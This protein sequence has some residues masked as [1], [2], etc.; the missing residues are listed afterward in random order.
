[1][2]NFV[3]EAG[4]NV[5]G[6]DGGAGC[7]SIR[8]EAHAQGR[9]RRRRRRHG[10]RRL[11]GRR[12][13][14]GVA[15]GLP[16]PPA[17]H[18][19]PAAPTA[20]GKKQ[21][22]PRR[23]RPRSC[24]CPRAPSSTTTTA[25]V[26]ADL[27]HAGDRWLAAA[28]GRGGKG[29]ARFLSNSRRAPTFAEQGEVGE[30][31]WLRLEL[32]LMAD[33]ALVGFPNVGKSHADLRGLGRQ[34]QDRRLPVHDA[35][36]QP[37]RGAP[38]RRR[39]D[40]GRRHPRPHRGRQRGQG[41]RPPVPPPRR[42]GPGAGCCCSTSPAA[43][44]LRPSEQER[45]LLDELE[46]YRPELLERPR[47]VVGVPRRHGRPGRSS[48]V[49]GSTIVS[50]VTGAG[51]AE[52]GRAPWPSRSRRARRRAPSPSAFVDPPA[53]ARGL[54][55]RA[56]RRAAASW[57]TAGR[58]PSAPSPCP[59]SPTSRRSTTCRSRLQAARRRQ[60]AGRG[61]RP[62]RRPRPHRQAQLRVRGQRLINVI[63]ADRR[64]QDRHVVD[65]RRPTGDID[66]DA[67]AKLC[68]EV[69]A[70]RAAGHRVV[71]VT[72]G[73]IAAGLPALGLGGDRRPTRRRH[74]PG[75][76]RRRPEPADARLRRAAS[77]ATAWWPARCCS[78]RS[79]S[80]DAPAVPA[81]PGHARPP[82]RA[83]RRAGRQRERRHRR[84]R[85]PLRRQR[86]HRRARGPPGRRRPAGAA[87]RRRR[88]A[89]RR[90]P[91]R[92]I[93]VAHRGD[94][95]RSTTSSKP[96]AGGAGLARGSGGMA[97][98]LAAAKIAAWSGVRAVIA[99]ADR[100]GVLADAVAGARGR[101][102]RAAPRRAALG[103]RKLWIAFA[104]GA[105]PG[106]RRRRGQGGGARR[107]VAAG[108]RHRAVDGT[109]A[110]QDAVE[111]VGPDGQVFAKGAGAHGFGTPRVGRRAR[112]RHPQG[113][114]GRPHLIDA[115]VS[116]PR[117]TARY[118]RP[119]VGRALRA[120]A[121]PGSAAA[122]AAPRSAGS[123]WRSRGPS[124][125]GSRRG[126]PGPRSCWPPA[127][128]RPCGSR[129]SAL[130]LAHALGL[131]VAGLDL[132]ADLVERRHVL[133]DGLRER[134]IALFICSCILA[135]SSWLRSFCFSASFC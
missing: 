82:A 12:P 49:D 109:F 24:R 113:R 106:A 36:A 7:V 92:P 112:R 75:R 73:A 18:G 95:S 64:G 107:Q 86:P 89:H 70:L 33:V 66:V 122:S 110:E 25:T 81:R 55:H 98:K 11:A 99:A 6:G 104:V 51:P 108:A 56:R 100:P 32:K 20:Q 22:R 16:R 48:R 67:V 103:A 124:A 5:K 47:V 132:V 4:L 30:E 135:C 13:Q 120:V 76:V 28:G 40:R 101:H 63:G 134:D 93:G 68:A 129:P 29:N 26:L 53:R 126:G 50:A 34:A 27:V 23:R 1:M 58:P 90:S 111:I 77:P 60:G 94:R 61:R 102:R 123:R 2:S 46:A 88:A 62:R 43:E 35:R 19:R 85:D 131:G 65:H 91:H 125:S 121:G 105:G 54:P 14:R 42:A 97:S 71:V 38:R 17:P 79:T 127:R 69:A 10:R 57:C 39:R 117:V 116:A 96:L 80:I 37:R 3:D 9:S 133:A 31:R 118:R 45:V 41:P 52:L 83:R 59:T 21:A 84:R 72:S 15:A 87:H 130:E 78:P 128:P 114:S 44:A 74:P 8:R 115:A 119:R